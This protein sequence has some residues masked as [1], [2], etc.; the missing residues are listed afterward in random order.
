MKLGMRE[1]TIL[2]PLAIGI[3]IVILSFVLIG[4]MAVVGNS[5]IIAL[6]ISTVPYFTYKY[7]RYAW[8][9]S[10]ERQFPNFIRDLADSR[11]SGVT[12]ETAVSMAS[13]TNY[14]KLTA[15]IKT[16][17]NKLSWG[18]PF[19]RVLE[20]FGE[21]VKDSASVTEVLGII[22]ESH[23]SG[24]NVVAT[25]DSAAKNMNMLREA[26]EE[27]KNITGQHV[28]ITYGIFFLF[29]GIVI[30]IIYILVPMIGTSGGI[31]GG[32]FESVGV[33][34]FSNPCAEILVPF[35]CGLFRS[36]CVMLGVDP[37]IISCYYISLFFYALLIQGIFSGLIAGQLGENS[38]VAGTKHSLIMI[39]I[40]LFVFIFFAKAGFFP[41]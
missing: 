36:T 23:K 8:V 12:L 13:K 34:T 1:K 35:P 21:K 10:I 6:F 29:L 20:I 5:V 9:K 26:D 31:V 32:D 38:I 39:S 22:K 3:S 30:M 7:S 2:V 27:R 33:S 11:R 18:V 17:A 37:E 4:D 14:G 40:A 24:G 25:L 41:A 28:M 19:I 15:E 16:M